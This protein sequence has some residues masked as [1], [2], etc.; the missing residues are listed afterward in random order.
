[1]L[2]FIPGPDGSPHAF[3]GMAVPFTVS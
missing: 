3:M 2:C 1:M